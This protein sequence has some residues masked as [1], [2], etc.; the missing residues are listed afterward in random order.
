MKGEG[1]DFSDEQKERYESDT[2]SQ[3][4]LL[5]LLLKNQ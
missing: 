5:L 2:D 4:V 1:N 3:L